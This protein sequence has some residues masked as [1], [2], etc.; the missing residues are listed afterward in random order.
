VVGKGEQKVRGTESVHKLIK[1][2]G[3]ALLLSNE[4]GKGAEKRGID[5]PYVGKQGTHEQV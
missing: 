1:R 2:N 5:K 4:K 3:R